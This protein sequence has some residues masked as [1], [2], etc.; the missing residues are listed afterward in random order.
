[1]NDLKSKGIA[2]VDGVYKKLEQPKIKKLMQDKI[3]KVFTKLKSKGLDK[4]K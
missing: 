3:D 2:Q 1:M 4:L